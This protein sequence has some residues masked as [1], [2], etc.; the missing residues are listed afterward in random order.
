[1][2]DIRLSVGIQGQAKFRV[3][4]LRTKGEPI[5]EPRATWN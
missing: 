1:M 3:I 5:L 2:L 4:L